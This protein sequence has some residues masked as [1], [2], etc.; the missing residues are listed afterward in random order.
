MESWQVFEIDSHEDL[1]LCKD[2]SKIKLVD[3][4]YN[5]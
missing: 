3:G 4:I 2:L 1:E 5:E